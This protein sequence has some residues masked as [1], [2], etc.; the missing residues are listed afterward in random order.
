[1]SAELRMLNYIREFGV[2]AVTGRPFLGYGELRRMMH[3]DY[4]VTMYNSRKKATNYATWAKDN[5]DAAQLLFD[6]SRFAEDLFGW[7]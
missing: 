3:A 6:A 4:I 1:M 5:P 7:E 2:E